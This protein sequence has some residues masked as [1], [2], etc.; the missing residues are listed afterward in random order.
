M[1]GLDRIAL[2]DT[3]HAVLSTRALVWVAGIVAAL[4]FGFPPG[5]SAPPEVRP[6]G[7]LVSLLTLPA[8]P[9]DAG[10]YLAIAQRGYDEPMRA[11]FFPLY[12]LLARIVTAPLQSPLIGGLLISFVAFAA[13][14]YLLHRLVALELGDRY[15]RPAVL[16][17]ALFPT[18]FFFSA[19]YTESLFLA[20]TV[21]AFYAARR[22]RWALAALAG[23]LAA[24]TRNTGVLLLVPRAMMPRARHRDALWLTGIPAGLLAVLAYWAQRG[25]A[26]EPFHAQR[27]WYRELS[28]LGGLVHGTWDAAVSAAQLAAGPGHHLLATPTYAQAG[29]LSSALTL[30][31]VDLTDVAF[32]AFAVLAL[33]GVARRLPLPYAV[34]AAITL[35]IAVSAPNDYEP[36]M[37]LPRYVAVIF[38]LQMWLATWAVD[39][40]RLRQTLTVCAGLLVL[41][42]AEF[43]TW[44]WV[45]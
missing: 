32:L 7:W 5:L 36:L 24:A 22:E 29:E 2:R 3:W 38:P 27:F 31:T 1:G 42:S 19:I 44:R 13:A 35:A 12:P 9:W 8:T 37:S 18:A 39:R 30:A 4:R 21:G 45:A 17:T 33:A 40:D 34:Y 20:L 6:Y 26:L 23:G 11:A 25:D 16:V 10:H 41:L 28:P 14:L 43:A 15:A